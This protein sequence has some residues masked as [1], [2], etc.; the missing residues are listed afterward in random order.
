MY[1]RCLFRRAGIR[2][3]ASTYARRISTG[4]KTIL[5]ASNRWSLPVIDSSDG[6]KDIQIADGLLSEYFHSCDIKI[7]VL[8]HLHVRSVSQ[9][10]SPDRCR[11]ETVLLPLAL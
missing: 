4:R 5:S 10:I 1:R 9:V 6:S 7:F 11:V 8:T 2:A 3:A